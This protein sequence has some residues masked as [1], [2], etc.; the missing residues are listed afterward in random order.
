[1]RI[2][3]PSS[4]AEMIA[5]FLRQEYASV[6][7]YGEILQACLAVESMSADRITAADIRNATHNEERRRLF[8]RYRG[9]GTR[10]SS[11]LTGFP[12]SGVVWNWVALN[13]EELLD[14]KY[15]RYDYWTELSGGTRSPRVAAISILAGHEAFGVSNQ[16]FLT[17]A[18]HLREG[19]V[20]PPLILVS[21][22]D[23][24]TRVVLEGHARI[25]GY[26]LATDFIPPSVVAILGVSPDIANWDEY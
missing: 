15:I 20:V 24:T 19:L 26:A 8:A 23:G 14:S 7:R 16:P 1:M 9:Y 10:Q 12:T 5:E 6:E 25:T 22:D 4:E 11:Y 21:A 17:L 18:H 13:P 2:V 3:R